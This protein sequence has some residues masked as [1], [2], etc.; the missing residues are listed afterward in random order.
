MTTDSRSP[1]PRMINKNQSV[2]R[3]SN[4]RH[5]GTH[6]PRLQSSSHPHLGRF[7]D[8]QRDWFHYSSNV[9][10]SRTNKAWSH[11]LQTARLLRPLEQCWSRS[12]PQHERF[13]GKERDCFHHSNNNV[14]LC[15][16]ILNVST[17]NGS[18]VCTTRAT[19]VKFAPTARS[20]L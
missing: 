2:H 20:F 9:D 11:R 14:I 15:T 19:L 5:M 13:N 18:A 8:Q 16:K 12:H 10:L 1:A 7:N 4:N 17:T 3:R 6:T